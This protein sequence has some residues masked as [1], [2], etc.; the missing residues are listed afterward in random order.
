[1]GQI[2][3]CWDR[4]RIIEKETYQTNHGHG[5]TEWSWFLYRYSTKNRQIQKRTCLR[6]NCE[7][8]SHRISFE[9]NF[10]EV[11]WLK[12][13][14]SRHPSRK[15]RR[16]TQR[17]WDPPTNNRRVNSKIRWITFLSKSNTA[18]KLR[19]QWVNWYR[20]SCTT[21]PGSHN[22]FR[23][24]QSSR[25]AKRRFT[26]KFRSDPNLRSSSSDWKAKRRKSRSL[27]NQTSY[28]RCSTNCFWNKTLRRRNK[29]I[30]TSGLIEQIRA[31]EWNYRIKIG[32]KERKERRNNNRKN[33]SNKG[34]SK[35][36][37][38][39]RSK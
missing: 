26:A 37:E 1:M 4:I 9:W 20:R 38:K 14:L 29:N 30:N 35:R 23:S 7:I 22:F 24:L 18:S 12:C 28:W 11:Y 32:R 15:A 33:W 19:R 36:R 3:F 27:I 21:K 8:R 39:R 5:D 2:Q 6:Q 34:W 31:K 13:P 17:S 25:I 10:R 16:F